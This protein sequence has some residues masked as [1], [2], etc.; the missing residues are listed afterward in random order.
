MDLV[1]KQ[2][3]HRIFGKGSVVKYDDSYIKVE[4][5]SGNKRFVFPDAFETYLTFTDQRAAKWVGKMVQERKRERKEEKLK[6]KKLKA[7]Q[8]EKRQHLLE[9][10]RLVV[11]RRRTH[12]IHPRSQSVFWCKAQEQDSI[13]ARWNI[14]AGVIKSG[15]KKGQPKRL[16]RINQN[17]A[18]LLTAR[19]SDVAEKDRRILGV[20]MVNE[21][22]SGKQC[23]DGYIP[24]H[25][26]YRLRLSEQE[27]E[28][29][30][31]WNYYVNKRYPQKMTWNAG[32]HRYFDN[33]WLAQILRDI[34]SFKKK[35]Q[36]RECVQRFFEYFCKMN[37]IEKGE[38]PKPNGALMRI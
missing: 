9:R 25:S 15:Q 4:F 35:P 1:N 13:F 19:D 5:S 37:R 38:L 7:L 2:V 21:T 36:E 18:C 3:M 10:E 31:F 24:A 33:I 6:L 27:S 14:F 17:S 28:K 11:K 12:G 16:V 20:F 8:N 22:F 23:V 29:M 34:V 26:E 32:R 30:L